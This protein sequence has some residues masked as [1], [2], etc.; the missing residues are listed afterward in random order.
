MK[1]KSSL[2]ALILAACCLLLGCSENYS[3]GSRVGYVTQF[4]KTG[5]FFKTWEGHLNMS[6]TGTNSSQEWDFG[7]DQ[8]NTPQDAVDS[9]ISR[10]T[11]AQDKGYKVKLDYHEVWGH[12]NMMFWRGETSYYLTNVT[13]LGRV[14]LPTNTLENSK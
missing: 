11:L 14:P 3:N 7:V 8:Q 5:I 4:S 9:M 1:K 13:I 12:S 10:L 6:Q 2:F